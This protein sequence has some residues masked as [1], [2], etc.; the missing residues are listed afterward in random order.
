M[1]G[2]CPVIHAETNGTIT[3]QK[4][5]EGESVTHEEVP[6]HDFAITDIKGTL[7]TTPPFCTGRNRCISHKTDSV[8][9]KFSII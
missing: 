1:V 3:D 2:V 4:G 7:S 8:Y 6:H 9:F 5:T